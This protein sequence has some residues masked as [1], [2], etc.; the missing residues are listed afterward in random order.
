MEELKERYDEMRNCSHDTVIPD[1][2]NEWCCEDCGRA[3]VPQESHIGDRLPEIEKNGHHVRVT[4]GKG[5]SNIQ[6]ASKILELIGLEYDNRYV[7]SGGTFSK[8]GKRKLYQYLKE[9][10]EKSGDEQN[11]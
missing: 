10:L 8:A 3:F 4:V 5:W 11:E 9:N 2:D 6:Y 7:N 1:D